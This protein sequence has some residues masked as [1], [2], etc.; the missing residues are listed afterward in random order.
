MKEVLEVGTYLCKEAVDRVEGFE[1]AAEPRDVGSL[2]RG[3]RERDWVLDLEFTKKLSLI[4]VLF[5]YA[6]DSGRSRL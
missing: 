4:V 2:N 3:L 6:V 5:K 1:Y